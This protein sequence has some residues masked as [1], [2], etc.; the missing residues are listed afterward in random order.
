M[1]AS[2][3]LNN[4]EIKCSTNKLELLGAVGVCEHFINYLNGSD[5]KVVTDHKA[6]I[7]PFLANHRNRTMHSRLTL[8]VNRL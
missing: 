5:F 2:R 3:F 6:L 4:H 1:L 8:W 7:S